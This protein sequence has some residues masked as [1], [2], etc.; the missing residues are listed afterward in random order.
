MRWV[1]WPAQNTPIKHQQNENQTNIGS[2]QTVLTSSLAAWRWWW[3]IFPHV[4]NYLSTVIL[5]TAVEP[6]SGSGSL[7]RFHNQTL[8]PCLLTH[9]TTGRGKSNWLYSLNSGIM[10]DQTEMGQQ[11]TTCTRL[12]LNQLKL[13]NILH[14]CILTFLY[15]SVYQELEK[16]HKIVKSNIQHSS[17]LLSR[18]WKLSA[19]RS[20][21]KLQVTAHLWTKYDNTWLHSCQ[22]K[23]VFN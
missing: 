14:I 16:Q 5:K 23:A 17:Y 21:N 8:I 12:P 3:C 15:L 1:K 2:S 11:K 9:C 22:S 4:C 18:E 20:I 7:H 6:S 13:V 10:G 19:H